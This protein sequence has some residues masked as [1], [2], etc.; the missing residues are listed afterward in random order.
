MQTCGT[1]YNT[2]HHNLTCANSGLSSNLGIAPSP[3][4]LVDGNVHTVTIQYNPPGKPCTTAPAGA[5]AGNLCVYIDQ[6]N[7]PALAVVA[8]LSA[9]GLTANG[10]AYVGFTGATGGSYETQDILSWSFAATVVQPFNPDGTT[11]SN[12]S[13]PGSQNTQT[14]D[15]TTAN[16]ALT[17]NTQDG[18][19]DCGNVQLK[20]TNTLISAS[21]AWKAYVNGT[22]WSISTC[23]AKAANGSDTCSLFVN[24]CFGGSIA[25]ANASDIY[26][27]V[28]NTEPTAGNTIS[29]SDTWDPVNPKIDPSKTPGTTVSLIDFVPSSASN[30]W[31][32]STDLTV[33]NS[34]CTSTA[35]SIPS[36][37]Y[38]CELSDSL[39]DMF[40]DQTTT[41]GSKPKKGWLISVF[42]VPM[43]LT[44]VN[45]LA[46]NNCNSPRSPLNNIDTSGNTVF[47]DPNY[48]ANVWNNGNCL[49]DFKVYPAAIPGVLSGGDSNFF[50]PAPPASLIYG[51][52]PTPTSGDGTA[53]NSNLS[54]P[55]SWDTGVNLRI[56]DFIHASDGSFVLHWSAT[57]NVGITER[58]IQLL[59]GATPA[60]PTCPEVTNNDT[61]PCYATSLFTTIVNVDST[62]PTI[63]SSVQNGSFGINSVVYPAYTCT[64]PLNNNVAS[65][66]SKCGGIAIPPSGSAC[67]LTPSAVTS[68]TKLDTSTAGV[69]NYNA[70]VSDCAG[71]TTTTTVTYT[72]T[73]PSADVALFEQPG[74]A[75][76]GT[77]FNAIFWALDL[78]SNAASNV[79]IN[80]SLN[81]PSGVLAP[82]GSV[83]AV[84]GLVSCTLAGCNTLTTGTTCTVTSNTT[85]SCPI[86]TLP[87][88]L[89]ITGA[90]VKIS[91]PIA[92]G[93]KGLEVHGQRRGHQR[94]RSQLEEQHCFADVH[95][96]QVVPFERQTHNGCRFQKLWAIRVSN[97]DSQ[98]FFLVGPSHVELF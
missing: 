16:G 17:C 20:T 91:I 36:N 55:A 50:S 70:S 92:S 40:G 31:S 42:N 79:T 27:P 29:F 52:G 32:P 63:S 81:L 47:E 74:S 34:A 2:S 54:V 59:P 64:D 14:F 67:P 60:Y 12:F 73:G 37:T 78:S 95:R 28:V 58:R 88:V 75:T 89:K 71:N 87:S 6:T 80:A 39:I 3:V 30:T 57:D 5:V 61:F 82:N 4:T 19:Q 24:A 7:T 41:K 90:A 1:G 10:N 86:G 35:G 96:Q 44:S 56:A 85:V 68:A 26:C 94:Q 8:D 53:T 72:V 45:V 22:P 18:T 46:G 65:G 97:S 15:T 9:I 84:A 21:Q 77:T 43:N 76:H 98:S 33:P 13:T 69:H 11:V 48:A 62:F 51:P 25:E 83:S 38:T 23:A 93:A 49:L 66:I